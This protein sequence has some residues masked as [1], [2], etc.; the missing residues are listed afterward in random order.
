MNLFRALHMHKILV[1]HGPN[2]N[3]LGTRDSQACKGR[4]LRQIDENLK[5]L[6]NTQDIDLYARQTNSEGELINLIQKSKYYSTNYIIINA[7]A[8]AYTSIAIRDALIGV[9]IPFI[10]LHLSNIHA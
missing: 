5:I 7:A 2:V 1:L 9:E 6:A 4:S 3:L 8:Y 10:E